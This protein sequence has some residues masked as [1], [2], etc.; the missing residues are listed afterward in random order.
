MGRRLRRTGLES[1]QLV[2]TETNLGGTHQI[3]LVRYIYQPE[4]QSVAVGYRIPRLAG[5]RIGADGGDRGH[6]EP[7]GV[8]RRLDGLA[9]RRR[10]LYST[11][12]S[13]RGRRA[14]SGETR[15]CVATRTPPSTTI[16]TAFPGSTGWSAAVGANVTRSFGWA[17]RTTSRS[18]RR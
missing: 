2:P 1:L 11:R 5:R 15:V 3:A 12:P 18:A 4:S 7:Q 10:P 6:L 17:T 14:P 8:A 16:R 9:R 13:G